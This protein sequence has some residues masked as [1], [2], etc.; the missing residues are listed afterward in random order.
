MKTLGFDVLMGQAWQLPNGGIWS[1]RSGSLGVESKTS[2]IRL[3]RAAPALP[4]SSLTNIP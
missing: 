2:D 1:F 4:D 3:L